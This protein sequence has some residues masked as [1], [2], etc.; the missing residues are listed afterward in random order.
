METNED[1]QLKEDIEFFKNAPKIKIKMNTL[2]VLLM[3]RVRE[4]Y[5]GHNETLKKYMNKV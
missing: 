3:L 2:Q 1:R 5:Q 4:N